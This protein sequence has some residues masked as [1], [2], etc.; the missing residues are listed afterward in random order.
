MNNT[1]QELK[2]IPTEYAAWFSGSSSAKYAIS[3]NTF[4]ACM[5][6]IVLLVTPVQKNVRANQ[7]KLS[8]IINL[9]FRRTPNL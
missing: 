8:K 9:R 5:K 7:I 6:I 2:K 1:T 3:F 4:I